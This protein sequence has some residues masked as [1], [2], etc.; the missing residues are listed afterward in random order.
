MQI[1]CPYCGTEYQIEDS[2]FGRFTTCEVCKKGFVA[3]TA[4][5]AEDGK[6]ELSA[7]KS[8]N[9]SQMNDDAKMELKLRKTLNI[10]PERPVNSRLYGRVYSAEE[11][12]RMYE[13]LKQKKV[14]RK[15]LKNVTE[16]IIWLLVLV[17]LIGG[18][19]AWIKHRANLEDEHLRASLAAE[20]ESIRLAEERD[21]LAREQRERSMKEREEAEAKLRAEQE[22]QRQ[23]E[24]VLARERREN[25]ERYEMFKLA[26][27]ENNFALHSKSVTNNIEKTGNDLCYLFPSTTFPAPLYWVKYSPD[28]S[29]KAS[30]IEHDGTCVEVNIDFMREK[31]EKCEYLV[32]KRDTVYF[33]SKRKS[34]NTGTLSKTKE[35]DP[36]IA[37]FGTLEDTLKWLQPSYDELTFDITFV[38]RK[39]GNK[40]IF[41]EN[42]AFGCAYSLENVRDAIVNANPMTTSGSGNSFK[43]GKFKRTVKFWNGT[44]IKQGLDGVT[45]VPR[46]PP[47]EPHNTYHYD[48]YNGNII[49]R[50]RVGT[51]NT[52]ERWSSLKVQAER[53][54]AEEREFY[55]RQHMK[56]QTARNQATSAA[57][58]E[59][60]KKIDTIFNEG[61]I[62]YTIRKAK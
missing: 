5:I 7:S 49:Y 27:R 46:M 23:E 42:V 39:S 45:Y 19:M 40:P 34:P 50:R 16:S 2:E 44:M 24:E 10:K 8:E 58:R 1:K 15:M 56:A 52:R 59:W 11:R 36:A 17:V 29:A 14:R 53:E 13:E 21:R 31:L 32:A 6:E 12:V 61:K 4:P 35:F 28:G 51:N 33:R 57:E 41:V 54:D 62:I 55:E 43:Y 30:R 3:G 18:Y 47:R 25:K 9:A 37:F 38:P 22:R 20:A 26:L 60:M 48:Y